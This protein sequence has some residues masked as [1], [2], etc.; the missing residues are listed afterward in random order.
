MLKPINEIRKNLQGIEEDIPNYIK[1]GIPENVKSD[2]LRSIEQRNNTGVQD[3]LEH[4]E[5]LQS[6]GVLQVG[7]SN[8]N[9]EPPIEYY[10]G[11]LYLE[12]DEVTHENIGMYIYTGVNGLGWWKFQS[13]DTIAHYYGIISDPN[14]TTPRGEFRPGDYYIETSDGTKDGDFLSIWLFTNLVSGPQF[15]NPYG[16]QGPAG[17]AGPVGPAGPAGEK[18]ATGEKGFDGKDGKDGQ[19]PHI[20]SNGN[21]WL[22]DQDTGVLAGAGYIT[23]YDSDIIGLRDGINKEFTINNRIRTGSLKVYFNGLL[24]T[25][26]NNNDFTELENGALINRVITPKD[27][28]IF[29]FQLT[30]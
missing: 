8:P 6:R 15:I 23:L 11:M 1:T 26:G 13:F 10:V 20:G 30:E 25:K 21:W 18:G 27:K 4:I 5:A 16:S 24:L 17:P 19:T 28:L 14:S 7:F 9:L 22:G 3:I 29:E 12:K 2:N